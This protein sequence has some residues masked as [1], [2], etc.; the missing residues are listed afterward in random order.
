MR[1]Q[2]GHLPAG[3]IPKPTEMIEA[4]LLVICAL[5]RRSEPHLV[6]EIARSG[7]VGGISE[8]GHDIAIACRSHVHNLADITG[9]QKFSGALIA[10][11]GA[12]LGAHLDDAV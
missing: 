12:L 4:A 3:V 1:A 2:V 5:G 7:A 6:I 8:A 9:S 11:A 10:L